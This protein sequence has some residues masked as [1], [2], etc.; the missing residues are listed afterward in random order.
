MALERKFI[1][2]CDGKFKI[3]LKEGQGSGKTAAWLLWGDHVRITHT[4]GAFAH[5]KARATEGWIPKSALTD[6]GLLEIYVI[7]VGQGDG[8][9]MR[10]PD[11]AWHVIDGGVENDVQMTKKGMANFIRWK[12]I[13]DLGKQKVRLRN[14]VL[15][16]PDFDHYGGLID[17]LTGK[18]KRPDREFGVEV[19]TFYHCGMGRFMNEPKLGRTRQG[20]VDQPPFD[21]YGIRET[22]TFIT[23]L[24]QGKNTFTTPSR[25]L[26]DTFGRFAA[27]VGS[28]PGV[29]RR[30]DHT[31]EYLPGYEEDEDCSIRVLGPIV[32][33][34]GGQPGLRVLGGESVTRNGHSIVLRVDFGKAKVLLTGDLN[35]ASQRLLLSYHPLDE[36]AVD[37]AKGCHHGSDDIDLRFVRAMKARV[38][39]IS[40][41]DNEDYAHPRPRVIGASARYGREAKAVD[42][43]LMPPLVYSTELARS[44][45]LAFAGKVRE[46]ATPGSELD[47]ANVEIREAKQ[48]AR[49]EPLDETPISTDLIYGLINIRTDG[50]NVVCA[51]MK[52][53]GKDFDV[54]AFKAGVEPQL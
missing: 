11:D 6:D 50:E 40:S 29:V 2:D 19:D 26:D 33:A 39:V 36:F 21:D 28:V 27:L 35:T 48:N 49:F 7:D 52:E 30:L 41:G 12:M 47:A 38:T 24:L 4:S 34:V 15:S 45:R 25:P 32:E 54:R 17:L 37:V 22:D 16:H 46:T 13:D 3:A 10:T 43:A 42:G 8:V 18:V 1:N 14:V 9:L 53:Q 51:Y 20:T 5:V 31:D 44:V 23:E